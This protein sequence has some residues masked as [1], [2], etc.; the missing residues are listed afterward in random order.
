[1]TREKNVRTPMVWLKDIDVAARTGV[2]RNRVWAW[3]THRPSAQ[4][5]KTGPKYQPLARR[6]DRAVGRKAAREPVLT[7]PAMALSPG[8]ADVKELVRDISALPPGY[9][10]RVYS[11]IAYA[12]GLTHSTARKPEAK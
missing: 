1:M 10:T 11:A 12:T 8:S 3:G 4:A 7:A 5:N 2:S 6:C 9:K